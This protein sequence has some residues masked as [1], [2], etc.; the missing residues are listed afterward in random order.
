MSLSN[1]LAGRLALAKSSPD[2]AQNND[3]FRSRFW[4]NQAPELEP[5]CAREQYRPET[6]S[7]FRPRSRRIDVS[8]IDCRYPFSGS[9]HY[10]VRPR[11]VDIQNR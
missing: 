9:R 3:S 11:R 5:C 10:G 8:S 6:I 1:Q 2:R 7:P 4:S